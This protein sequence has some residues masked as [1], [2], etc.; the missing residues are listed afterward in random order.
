MAAPL[1]REP[2]SSRSTRGLGFRVQG[3]GFRAR[4]RV[5]GL[6]FY[7]KVLGFKAGAFQVQGLGF[8]LKVRGYF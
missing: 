4:F 2:L 7:S 3:S 5:Q 1:G 6:G 8:Y